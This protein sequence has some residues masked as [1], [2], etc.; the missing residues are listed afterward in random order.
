MPYHTPST[1]TLVARH[2]RRAATTYF[3]SPASSTIRHTAGG[4]PVRTA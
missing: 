2:T 3:S 4:R 1:F